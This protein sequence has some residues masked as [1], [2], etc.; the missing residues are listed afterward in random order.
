MPSSRRTRTAT[1]TPATSPAVR[2]T[3]PPAADLQRAA[4]VLRSGERV[5]MLVG[6]G[7][8]GAEAE[9]AAIAARLGA[10]VATALLGMAVVDQREPWV[11]GSIGLL[12]TRPSWDLMQDCDRLLIV[13]SGMPYS[14]FY[15]P[16]GQARAVQIDV[17]G[18]RMGLR[19]PTEVNLTGDAA[20]TLTALLELLGT[21]TGPTAW[22]ERV[23]AGTP[24]VGAGPAARSPGSRPTRSTRS[25][26]SARSTPG[27]RPTPCSPSTAAPP[28]PGT[29]AT[30]TCGPGCWPACPGRCCRWAAAMPY[31]IAAKFAHPDRPVDRAARRRRDA[32]E[33]RQRADHRGEVLAELGRPAAS[34]C[35]CSTTATCPSSAGSSAAA[36]ARRSSTRA[37]CC[38]TS[39]TP[40]G[41]RRS[42]CPAYAW[43]RP[44]TSTRPGTPPCR[45][46]GRS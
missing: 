22:R 31:A 4:D 5:A 12:G 26:T 45:P 6:Q 3:V 24:V 32:D 1:T 37:S 42:A 43:S 40:T 19:Y 28:P 9:V 46:T 11:T 39:A 2:T 36:R 16:E 27:C 7:A 35:W 33:R 29:P 10:G 23:E 17:D 30:C 38:P 21:G 18:S 25:G 41:R 34:S 8:F 20:A 44:T 14:E 13:G 15:P